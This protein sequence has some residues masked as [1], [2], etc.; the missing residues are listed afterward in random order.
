MAFC[1]D[2]KFFEFF[3]DF[4]IRAPHKTS[5]AEFFRGHPSMK[6]DSEAEEHSISGKITGTTERAVAIPGVAQSLGMVLGVFSVLA[7]EE[8]VFRRI[9]KQYSTINTLNL[10]T[11]K[12]KKY[13]LLHL[14]LP[15]ICTE[16]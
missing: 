12:S 1:V 15:T 10:D 5:C 4:Y 3:F 7:E 2:V 14:A 11:A 6:G 8:E 16:K 9:Q 13:D